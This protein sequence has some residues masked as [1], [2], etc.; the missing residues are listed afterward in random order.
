MNQS[1][2]RS[3]ARTILVALVS[4]ATCVA[5]AEKNPTPP[6]DVPTAIAV[7]PSFPLI[8]IAHA[9]GSQIYACQAGQDGKFVWSLKAPEAELRDDHGKIIGSHFA[10]PSWKLNDGSVVTGRVDAHVDSPDP[11]S[12]P[13]L[14][15]DALTHDGNGKLTKVIMIQRLYTHGGKPPATG[16]DESHKDAETKSN[17]SADYYFY[18]A[19]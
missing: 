1:S 6:T 13:W 10:G 11:D 17:Y 18:A 16:C 15:L 8:L 3:I 5:I 14:H 7:P 12:I 2:P 9:T 4:F 19:L